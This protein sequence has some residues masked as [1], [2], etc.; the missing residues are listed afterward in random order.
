MLLQISKKIVS[1]LLSSNADPDQIEI[2]E[3]GCEILLY[4]I[5]STLGLVI[6]GLLLHSPI[7]A[8]I[9]ILIFYLFQSTGGGH[10]ANSHLACFTTMA[11]GLIFGLLIIKFPIFQLAAPFLSLCSA[12]LLVIN[13]LVLHHNKYYL[14]YKSKIFKIRS[15]ILTIC[16]YLCTVAFWALKLNLFYYASCCGIFFAALS[17]LYAKYKN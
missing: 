7:E 6:I 13:P 10:H 3:Y 17:R 5:I 12:I 1:Y 8:I 4:T 2:C 15:I 11:V 16:I 9:I 14:N